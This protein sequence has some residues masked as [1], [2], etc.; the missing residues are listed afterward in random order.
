MTEQ[1]CTALM[2]QAQ[3]LHIP[4]LA[5]T[6]HDNCPPNLLQATGS[7]GADATV[8]PTSW[9]TLFKDSLAQPW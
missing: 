4:H 1:D 2:D 3:A 6:F 5:W 7:C 9:G 8:E